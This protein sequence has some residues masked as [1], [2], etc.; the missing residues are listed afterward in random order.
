MMKILFWNVRGFG[1]SDS[2]VALKNYY[3][4]H[5]PDIIFLAEPMILYEQVPLWY[6]RSLSI[7]KFCVNV[8]LPHQPNLWGLW[9]NSLTMVPLFISD[10]CLAFEISDFNSKVYVAAVYANTS[11]LVRRRL[12][13]DLT[14]L[15]DRYVGPWL[16]VGDFNAVLG[17]HEK[18]GKRLPPKLSCDDFLLWTNANQ[19]LHLN[20]VGVRFTW[21]NGRAGTEYVSLRLDRSICNQA[22]QMHWQRVHC[23]S[24]FKHTSDHHPLLISQDISSVKH[25]MPFRF[26]KVWTSHDDCTWLVQDIGLNQLLVLLC[27]VYNLN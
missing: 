17:A 3:F 6:W 2:R 1:N 12:W 10:Q 16:F 14:M 19:L 20:T 15:Q 18:R 21:G 8:R 26:F 23:C 22:W 24:L 4:T 27:I 7:D 9:G 13:A 25:A 11:Y 5:K